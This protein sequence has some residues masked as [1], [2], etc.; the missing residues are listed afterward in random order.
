[1]KLLNFKALS[2]TS[3]LFVLLS[4]STMPFTACDKAET[5]TPTPPPPPIITYPAENNIIGRAFP[6]SDFSTS[7][8]SGASYYYEMGFRF[9]VTKKG[10]L[11]KMGVKTPE[12]GTYRVVLWDATTKTV[13]GQISCTHQNA[14]E[15]TTVATGVVNLAVGKDYYI[16]F[17]TLG[18][19]RYGITPKV[20]TTITYP[21]PVGFINIKEYGYYSALL[22][23]DNGSVPKFP[24]TFDN[25]F[26]R[27]FPEFEF[28][29]DPE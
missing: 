8:V 17:Q 24:I 15:Y 22:T 14:L 19:Q 26:A 10:K 9:S 29:P 27:G 1:M 3:L 23:A 4:F 20:G 16:T 2:F 12:S 25:G 28:Q 6:S 7:V 13:L 11:T 18:Q 21:R 5:P